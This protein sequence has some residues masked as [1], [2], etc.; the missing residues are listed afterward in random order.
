[1][2]MLTCSLIG[3]L[4]GS[5]AWSAE[6]RLELAW[7]DGWE[8]RE[9]MTQGSVVR[10]QARQRIGDQTAQQLSMTVID[11]RAARQPVTLDS[12]KEL[13][14]RLRSGAVANAQE[15]SIPLQPMQ[16]R[17]GYYFIATDKR[18]KADAQTDFRQM[19]EGVMLHE[20]YVI[21]FTLATDEASSEATQQMLRA[22]DQ[23]TISVR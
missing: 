20:D 2:R 3:V 4:L 1:M 22:L 12:I 6:P 10:L 14:E 9:P 15:R 18:H 11:A 13:A 8:Y 17:R 16:T 23:L 19:I 21:N 7:P 5:V